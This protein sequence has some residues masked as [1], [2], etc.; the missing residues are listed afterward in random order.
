MALQAKSGNPPT[1]SI[2]AGQIIA[3][4]GPNHPIIGNNSGNMFSIGKYRFVGASQSNYPQQIGGLNFAS[5]DGSANTGTGQIPTGNNVIRFS[6][7]YGTRLQTVVN[8][9]SSGAG[10]FRL[11]GKSRYNNNGMIGN[12]NE[13]AVVG[14]FRDRPTNTGGTKVHI[15]VN[16]QIG[17]ERFDQDHCALRTGTWNSGTTLQVDLG[18]SAVVAG[19]GGFGGNGGNAPNIGNDGGAGTS[20][21]GVQYNGTTVNIA[22]GAILSAGF[23][24]G[25]GGGG[26]FDYDRKSARW[27]SGGGGGGGAGLPLGLG[28][29][30]GNAGNNEDVEGGAGSAA[31]S[32]TEAGEGGSGGNNAGEAVGA[33]GGEGGAAGEAGDNGGTGTGGE[34]SSSRGGFGGPT[35]AAMRRTAGINVT[36]N[37]LG[38]IYGDTNATTVQ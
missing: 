2:S 24:G 6:D 5:I 33:A 25:G 20:G 22:S 37:N 10:G 13:V 28:G 23:G 18:S 3:E 16:Q 1:N 12:N 29:Q 34:G 30:G 36:I 19:A 11:I 32:L 38:T 27:G 7:F 14:G 26:A 4:F 21:L 31:T 8:F 15:H 9:W 17:S 35:G